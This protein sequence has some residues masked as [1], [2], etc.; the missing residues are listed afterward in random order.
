L[1]KIETIN[2]LACHEYHECSDLPF[3]GRIGIFS[4]NAFDHWRGRAL[5]RGFR[6]TFKRRDFLNDHYQCSRG[7]KGFSLIRIRIIYN[8]DTTS[9]DTLPA[10]V[11]SKTAIENRS[12][13]Y[14]ASRKTVSGKRKCMEEVL[15]RVQS[16]INAKASEQCTANIDVL[17]KDK[18][19]MEI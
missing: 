17:K 4:C 19:A 1:P 15:L 16:T 6:Q 7:K 14:S 18:Q 12:N 9:T 5:L 8:G 11:T 3:L 13:Q 2:K 10:Q